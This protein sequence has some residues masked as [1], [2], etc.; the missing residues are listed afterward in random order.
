[1]GITKQEGGIVLPK[2][3]ND[4]D[5]SELEKE[6]E[7][8]ME[9]TEE[10]EREEPVDEKELEEEFEKQAEFERE[11]PEEEFEEVEEKFPGYAERFYELS[12]REFE[13]EAE[14][15]NEVNSLL[16]EM[17]RDFFFKG[18]WKKVKKAGKGLLKKG[19][20]L[21]EGLPSFQAI[22][23]ITSLAR[24]DLKGLLGSLAKTGLGAVVPGGGVALKALGF[25]SSEDPEANR[26]AWE[27]YVDLSRRAFENLARNLEM[28]A[29][30]PLVASRIANEAFQTALREVS[31]AAP[32]AVSQGKRYRV[33]RVRPGERIV[34]KGVKN[35]T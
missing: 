3:G 33:I 17:E 2:G 30:D 24:G 21:A 25:E 16:N 5:M 34:I 35:Q 32:S 8:E 4:I 19:L 23:G 27:N 7:L 12:Q 10:K 6:F 15:D 31:T 18:L 20:K 1:M 22:K 26:E 29:D 14:V 13:S 9:E 11:E 28:N